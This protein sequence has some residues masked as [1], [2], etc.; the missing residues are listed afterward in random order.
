M[1]RTY[2]KSLVQS[3]QLTVPLTWLDG[4]FAINKKERVIVCPYFDYRQLSNIKIVRLATL[5]KHLG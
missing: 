4:E 3:K 2:A 5:I 1:G